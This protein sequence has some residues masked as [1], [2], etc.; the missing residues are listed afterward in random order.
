MMTTHINSSQEWMGNGINGPLHKNPMEIDRR[1]DTAVGSQHNQHHHVL[2][3]VNGPELHETKE[4]TM[5]L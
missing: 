1:S 2:D 3:R 4:A 5:A